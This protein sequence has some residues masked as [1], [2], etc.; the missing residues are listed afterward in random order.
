MANRSLKI[1]FAVTLVTIIGCIIVIGG[2]WS[3]YGAYGF[4]VIYRRGGSYW[5]VMTADDP[6]LSPAMRASLKT[7][8]P[9]A[10]SGPIVWTT[11]SLGFETAEMPVIVEGKTLDV[12][13]L[14]R[15]DPENYSFTVRNAPKGDIGIDEWEKQL[16]DSLLIVNG[17]YFGLKGYPDT[18]VKMNGVFAGPSKY[19]ATAGAFVS[20][21]GQAD[22]IDLRRRNWNSALEHSENAMVS[23]PLLI[24]DDG[25]THVTTQSRWL[26]NRTFVGKDT[27]GRIIIGT[28]Q[29]AFF[30]LDSLAKFLRKAPLGLTLALNLDGGPIACQSVRIGAYHRKL[31]ARWEAQVSGAGVKL[32]SWPLNSATWAMPMALTVERRSDPMPEPGASIRKR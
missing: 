11:R 12:I 23:Y 7:P 25:T 8:Q 15:I 2:I 29:D 26:A 5:R 20:R 16:P 6:R 32:L 24:G 1:I 30:N 19:Q 22:I 14:N 3:K 9:D 10:V 18:P 27:N 21:D 4:G 13:L 31:Y 17:S 28:T